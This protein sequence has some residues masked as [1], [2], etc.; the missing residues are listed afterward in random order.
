[1]VFLK[2]K[3]LELQANNDESK[4]NVHDDWIKSLKRVCAN[5][6]TLVSDNPQ[7]HINEALKR[8][9]N[10][11][12][13]NIGELLINP[14]EKFLPFNFEKEEDNYLHN[15]KH[16]FT[17]SDLKYMVQTFKAR[18]QEL[19][20]NIDEDFIANIKDKI[21]PEQEEKINS[22]LDQASNYLKNLNQKTNQKTFYLENYV[23]NRIY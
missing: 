3:D 8:Q 20:E 1:L 10:T 12:Q 23:Y 15:Q 11:G 2:E 16:V 13:E 9:L 6:L 19:N 22:F 17:S 21:I 7:K 5:K 14:A 18:I 4:N